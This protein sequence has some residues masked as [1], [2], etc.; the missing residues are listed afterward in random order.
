LNGPPPKFPG[1]KMETT[2]KKVKIEFRQE[3]RE[4]VEL[5]LR[6]FMDLYTDREEGLSEEHKYF[7]DLELRSVFDKLSK[8]KTHMII[9]REPYDE[10]LKTYFDDASGEIEK[11]VLV[12]FPTLKRLVKRYLGLD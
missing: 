5:T 11:N 8:R 2:E 3:V 7:I 4:S 9:H 1:I 10:G 12:Q 6:E